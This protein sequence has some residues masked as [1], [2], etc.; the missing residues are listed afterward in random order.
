MAAYGY[1]DNDNKEYVI[2]RP[3]TPTPWINYIGSGGYSGIVSQT[4]GGLCFDGDPSNRRVTRY[5]FN[6]LPADRPGRYLYIRDMESGEYWSP[7]WQ[8]VMKPMDFYECRHGL[9]YTVITGEYSGI[10]TTMTY[11]VPPGAGYEL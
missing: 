4:G 2:T 7:T 10:R 6:N 3:D 8:P 5:K 1:F 11:F 9:G